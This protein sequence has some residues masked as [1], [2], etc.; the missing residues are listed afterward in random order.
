MNRNEA[1]IDSFR[2]ILF[3]NVKYFYFVPTKEERD[4][5]YRVVRVRSLLFG[6]LRD[7][8]CFV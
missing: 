3:N 7:I 2:V 4:S 5:G 1:V 6:G 8:V